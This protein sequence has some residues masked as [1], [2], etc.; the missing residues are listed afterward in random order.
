[1][2]TSFAATA[3]LLPAL[4]L[5]V[6]II[7]GMFD[8]ILLYLHQSKRER[9]GDRESEKAHGKNWPPPNVLLTYSYNIII[10]WAPLYLTLKSTKYVPESTSN[11]LSN[12]TIRCPALY[13]PY[14]LC[15]RSTQMK[16]TSF[17]VKQQGSTSVSLW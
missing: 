11:H 16:A 15:L 2:S 1:M 10:A 4:S 8:F 7:N 9:E 13:S 17:T 5:I 14:F 3:Q 12:N 6:T